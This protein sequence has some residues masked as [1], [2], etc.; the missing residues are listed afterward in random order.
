MQIWDA[1]CDLKFCN[2]PLEVIFTF[3][4][5]QIFKGENKPNALLP[6]SQPK[7]YLPP[8]TT[9]SISYVSLNGEKFTLIKYHYYLRVPAV[10]HLGPRN[11]LFFWIDGCSLWM[12]LLMWSGEYDLGSLIGYLPLNPENRQVP[13][14]SEHLENQ[15]LH[16]VML[17]TIFSL[18]SA[19]VLD[20]KVCSYLRGK[21]ML[22]ILPD[23]F[24]TV[25]QNCTKPWGC[26]KKN[27]KNQPIL[28]LFHLLFHSILFHV[29]PEAATVGP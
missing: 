4:T 28:P 15:K 23:D 10:L 5:L 8:Y 13:S 2:F 6:V 22:T 17:F 24:I 12:T 20:D 7:L 18:N 25:A 19:Y 14:C 27:K 9:F 16:K 3:W 26:K 11:S 1:F 21:A 29:K